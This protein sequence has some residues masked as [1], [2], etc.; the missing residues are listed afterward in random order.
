MS[1]DFADPKSLILRLEIEK[2][3]KQPVYTMELPQE[4]QNRPL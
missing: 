2:T 4:L 1:S 3:K